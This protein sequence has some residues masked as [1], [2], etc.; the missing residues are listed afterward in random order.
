[1][2]TRYETEL[3]VFSGF[4]VD[5]KIMSWTICDSWLNTLY[6]VYKYI[7]GTGEV[8][9]YFSGAGEV[10]VNTA[11]TF[12]GTGEVYEISPRAFFGAGAVSGNCIL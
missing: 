3:L 11:R 1:M 10:Y 7:S 9:K 8:Y 2:N 12:S 6:A 5:S 4:C